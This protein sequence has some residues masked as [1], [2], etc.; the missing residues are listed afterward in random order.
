M[1][2][3]VFKAIQ[4]VECITLPDPHIEE[5]SD[6][7]IRLDACGIC[8]SD[9]HP[10]HGREQ[11]IDVD[12]VM[13]HEGAGTIVAVGKEVKKFKVGDRVFAPFTTNCGNCYYCSIGLTCRCV[14][15]ALFG[16]RQNK[17]GLHGLQA[18][19][20][21][22][23]LA[24]GTLVK[25]PD[26]VK[27]EE[28]LLLGDVVATGYH[29][30]K[31]CAEVHTLN[32]HSVTCVVGLGPVGIYSVLG[33]RELG[34][35]KIIALDPMA[36]RRALAEKFGAI[37]FWGSDAEIKQ[38]VDEHTEGRGADSCIEAVG[39][40]KPLQLAYSVMRPGGC[41][42]VPG[43]H[44]ENDFAITPPQAYDKNITFRTGRTP[45]RKYMEELLYWVTDK[46]I[47][48]LDLVSH[49]MPL[50]EAVYGYKIFDEK[51]DRC[52]KVILKP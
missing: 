22:I 14:S 11:G 41:L 32:A 48:I 34:A 31:L 45:A 21:R 15:G 4:Q 38:F 44:P 46:R 43:V 47:P 52:T 39:A 25:I 9:L 3:L 49:V 40:P 13:G 35:K 19:L 50:S 20:A 42:S 37:S 17:K 16:W 51:L 7:V 27:S 29:A 26:G 12:T 28:A 6:V 1:K 8:G 30:A 24:D 18:E 2:A 10:F 5:P 23:P 33:A 36:E